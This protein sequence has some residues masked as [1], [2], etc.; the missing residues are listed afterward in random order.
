MVLN[1]AH[2]HTTFCQSTNDLHAWIWPAIGD[3]KFPRKASSLQNVKPPL[4]RH[5]IC[6]K[7]ASAPRVWAEAP[8]AGAAGPLSD[9]KPRPPPPHSPCQDTGSQHSTFF[10]QEKIERLHRTN[11]TTQIQQNGPFLSIKTI[12]LS[13]TLAKTIRYFPVHSK[14]PH[15]HTVCG[16]SMLFPFYQKR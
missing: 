8:R 6:E 16:I 2:I 7:C 14:A 13:I 4:K 12:M 11:Q 1:A 15:F 9:S 10:I 5:R 3:T